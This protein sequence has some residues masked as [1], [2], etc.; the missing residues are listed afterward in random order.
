VV[1]VRRLRLERAP[2]ADLSGGF[3]KSEGA[4]FR[5]DRMAAVGGAGRGV[6]RAGVF[7]VQACLITGGRPVSRSGTVG[8]MMAEQP[9]SLSSASGPRPIPRKERLS[10]NAIN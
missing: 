6:S 8:R 2:E 4:P 3:R 1:K 9:W 5:L 10:Q 7:L